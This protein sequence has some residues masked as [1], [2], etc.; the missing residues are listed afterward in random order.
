MQSSKVATLGQ[1]RV[2]FK[3][4]VLAV[5]GWTFAGTAV[6][7]NAAASTYVDWLV[8]SP[9]MVGTIHRLQGAKHD[10]SGGRITRDDD[11]QKPIARAPHETDGRL[12]CIK[13]SAGQK[14][15]TPPSQLGSATKS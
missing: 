14:A 4:V 6:V 9:A 5:F 15:L 7:A 11:E 12:V 1:A 8:A 13:S 2:P 3:P 10:W